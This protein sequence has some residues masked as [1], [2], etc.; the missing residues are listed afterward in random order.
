ML[1]PLSDLRDPVSFLKGARIPIT[2][3]SGNRFE[4]VGDCAFIWDPYTCTYGSCPLEHMDWAWCSLDLSDPDVARW[5]D[6]KIAAAY[7]FPE[8]LAAVL[9]VFDGQWCIHLMGVKYPSSVDARFD[10]AFEG[11]PCDDD[12]IPTARAALLR[13][14]FGKETP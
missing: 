14:L 9:C 8:V 11:I 3:T 13:A 7:S 5:V 10:A 12:N 2:S 6:R 4:I 1:L